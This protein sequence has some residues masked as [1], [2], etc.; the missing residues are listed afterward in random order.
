MLH[1]VGCL[2]YIYHWCTVKQISNNEIYLLIKYIK[3]ILWR[4]TK[5]L[6]Y[7]EDA[8]CLKV[9][10]A[11]L[12]VNLFLLSGYDC[13]FS[14]RFDGRSCCVMYFYNI[15]CFENAYVIMII[16]KYCGLFFM[17]IPCIDMIS[18]NNNQLMHSLY[19]MY[20]C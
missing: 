14:S 16:L 9:N 19:K 17:L 3:S 20:G 11:F 8:R 2:Y 12:L 4:V 1:L 7:I 10:V 5:C 15:T 13:R 18:H 6:S